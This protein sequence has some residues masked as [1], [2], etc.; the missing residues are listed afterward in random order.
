MNVIYK[1]PSPLRYGSAPTRTDYFFHPGVPTQVKPEDEEQFKLMAARD[2]NPWR[3]EGIVEAATKTVAD[4]VV[5]A[6]EKVT[7]YES[8]RK[9]TAKKG[10]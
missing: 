6:V 3:I 10:G 7:G 5:E 4:T 8:K 1:G 9:T 2:S